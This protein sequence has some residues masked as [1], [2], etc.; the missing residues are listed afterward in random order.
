MEKLHKE[1]IQ[2]TKE[3]VIKFIESQRVSPANFPEMFPAIFTVVRRTIGEGVEETH[4]TPAP[5]KSG[6][7]KAR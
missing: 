1:A 5:A 3:I 6:H 4:E 2:V 7:D